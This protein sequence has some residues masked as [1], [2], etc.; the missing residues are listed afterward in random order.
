MKAVDALRLGATAA[1]VFALA[2]LYAGGTI[3]GR[4]LGT[5]AFALVVWSLYPSRHLETSLIVIA[6][7]AIS[8]ASLNIP[9]FVRGLFSAYGGSGFWIIIS[10]FILAKGMEVSGLGRRIAF[11]IAT[12]MG[13]KPRN[14]IV[15]VAL[16][17]MLIAPLS[18]STTAKAF[19]VLPVCVGLIEAFGVEKGRS[20]YG[21]AVMMMA[22][23]ANNVCSTAFL[24]ATIPNPISAEYLRA[25]GLGLDWGSWLVMA[26]PLTLTLLAISYLLVVRLFPPEVVPSTGIV[27][28]V[29]CLRNNLGP[30]TRKEAYVAILF[31]VSLA[32]WIGERYIPFNVGIVTL[33]LSLTLFI[34]NLR[35]ME[36]GR[37]SGSVPWGSIALFAA[38]MFMARAV[39]RYRALTPIAKGILD[40]LGPA[41]L[42]LGLFVA[43]AVFAAMALHAVFTSTT[44]YATVIV[45]IAISLAALQGIDPRLLGLPVAFLA[46]V[47][48][49][50]PVNTIPNIVFASENWFTTKQFILYGVLL[51]LASVL[52]VLAVGIPY[53]RLTGFA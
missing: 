28:K 46:P 25:A 49:F 45:P 23:V 14:I 52:L 53:W 17:S 2:Y 12:S 43:V 13:C 33:A 35:V 21:A 29:N 6:L 10:G 36:V 38:S 42:S 39:E 7:I 51:S 3:E 19:L 22:M 44:V 9:E 41:H 30:L 27:E 31:S 20:N 15:A 48:V 32:L 16:A 34:P 18:P 5:I 8:E 4:I 26:L 50:L 11:A 1:S 24:T 47:A 37:F 40:V